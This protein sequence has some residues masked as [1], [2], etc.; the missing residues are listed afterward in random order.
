MH[1]K[2]SRHKVLSRG[3]CTLAEGCALS[4]GGCESVCLVI[5]GDENY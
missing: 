5:L 3:I 1:V 4:K 2:M